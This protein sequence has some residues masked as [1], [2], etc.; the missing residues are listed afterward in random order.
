MGIGEGPNPPLRAAT[1]Q[2]RYVGERILPSRAAQS[3]ERMG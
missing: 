3:E 1:V 2:P